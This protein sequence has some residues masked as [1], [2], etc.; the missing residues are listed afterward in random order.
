MKTV[1]RNHSE[2]TH[3]WAQQ[4]QSNG[5]CGNV[6]FE[7]P[8]IFSYAHHFEIARFVTPQIVFMNSRSYSNSTSRHQSYVRGAIAENKI[9]FTVPSMTDHNENVR[10][11]F[12]EIKEEIEAFS[13]RRTMIN[14][15][16]EKIRNKIKEL[17]KYAVYFVQEITPENNRAIVAMFENV[18]LYPTAFEIDKARK[19][20]AVLTESNKHKFE[21]KQAREEERRK[22]E[23]TK[24][25]KYLAE[26]LKGENGYYPMH[27]IEPIRLRLREGVVQTT[28][29][30]EVPI[31]FCE[32]FWKKLHAKENL[33]GLELGH[34]RIDAIDDQT[35]VAGCHKIPMSEIRRIAMQ[36]GW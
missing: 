4:N 16:I 29:G 3:V 12:D 5:K 8:S 22:L 27:Y 34:Y 26:W 19:R 28:R 21:R 10:H 31:K 20:E 15:T 6:F 23:A 25:E 14:S 35:L 33:I 36:L 30:A 13:R 32:R 9:V 17:N 18:E 2:V 11:Y 7:G 1:F 24:Q